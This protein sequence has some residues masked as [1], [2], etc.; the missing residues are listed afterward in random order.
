VNKIIRH[1]QNEKEQLNERLCRFLLEAQHK[2]ISIENVLKVGNDSLAILFNDG[3]TTTY[4]MLAA[5][6]PDFLAKMGMQ[7]Q[8]L[9]PNPN[10]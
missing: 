9:N 7:L 5:S 10:P 8:I 3:S 6:E 2:T 4:K 1:D